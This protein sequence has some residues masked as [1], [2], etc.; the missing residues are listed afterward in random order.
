[1]DL[2][3]KYIKKI[4]VGL[5]REFKEGNV[6]KHYKFKS[7]CNN[8]IPSIEPFEKDGNCLCG[9]PIYNNYKYKHHKRD[10][11]FILGSCCIERFS[12][13][14]QEE[15]EKKRKCTS[16]AS[17]IRK[18]KYNL[19]KEC[20]EIR[21]KAEKAREKY[22]EKCKCKICGVI[23]KDDTYKLCYTCK[24]GDTQKIYPKCTNC[25]IKKKEDTYRKC[26]K[27]NMRNKYDPIADNIRVALDS[28]T[29]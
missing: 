15:E 14:Y 23:K 4:K 13:I 12:T 26:Y 7:F 21:K 16:C 29:D 24:F 8:F 11:V 17:D 18:N 6:S 10:D 9:H 28:W 1:M 2:N 25:G 20:R 5:E 27:C 19:C 3:D 22:E